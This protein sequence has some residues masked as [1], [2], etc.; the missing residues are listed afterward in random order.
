VQQFYEL[1]QSDIFDSNR[2]VYRP[3]SAI[4]YYS[5]LISRNVINKIKFERNIVL[6]L[7]SCVIGKKL[8]KGT[9]NLRFI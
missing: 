8:K 2:L 9:D 3:H 4:N 7:I 6:F 5:K 1:V